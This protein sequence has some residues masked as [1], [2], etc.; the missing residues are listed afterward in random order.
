MHG[1][2][3]TQAQCAALAFAGYEPNRVIF[4]DVPTDTILE[5]LTLRAVDPISGER[6]GAYGENH[7]CTG[8]QIAFSSLVKYKYLHL[9]KLK[10]A[11]K[12]GCW[13]TGAKEANAS[14]ALEELG[15]GDRSALLML[16]TDKILSHFLLTF[17][18]LSS[19]TSIY[20]Q[21][22]LTCHKMQQWL[23]A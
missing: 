14:P 6:Y 7:P 23:G 4:L 8:S 17:V 16:C 18:L 13:S 19:S 15:K 2:P 20:P 10:D 1:F 5:R 22:F 3:K 21:G 9:R 12:Q 11:Q